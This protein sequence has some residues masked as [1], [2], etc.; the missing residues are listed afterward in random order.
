MMTP[1]ERDAFVST[2]HTAVLATVDS[3][4]RA[5]AVPVWYLY[6]DGEFLVITDR[7]SQKHRNVERSGRAAICI[8]DRTGRFTNITAEGLVSVDPTV[9][10]EFRQR[11]HTHYRGAEAAAKSTAGDAHEHMVVLR[12]K[13]ER[14][15]G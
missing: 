9:T 8:D 7:G 14:W 10:R 15:L 2:P 12:L 3:K 6:E 11:L 4:G 13:P 5:H 1:E